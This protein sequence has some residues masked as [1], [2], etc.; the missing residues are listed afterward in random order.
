MAGIFDWIYFVKTT[1]KKKATHWVA[2]L[3]LVVE[4]TCAARFGDCETDERG[5]LGSPKSTRTEQAQATADDY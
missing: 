4:W 3:F 5:L 1:Q 2:F